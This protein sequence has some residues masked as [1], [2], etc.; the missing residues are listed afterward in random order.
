DWQ[1]T[2]VALVVCPLLAAAIR[3]VARHITQV[4]TDAR[5]KES[6]LYS[7][8]QRAM[9]SIKVIQAFTSEEEEHR[10]FID[11][12]RA[13]LNA[14]LNLYTVQTAYSMAVNVIGALGTA[15]VIWFGA[16]HVMAGTLTIGDLLVFTTYLASLYAPINTISNTYG[17]IQGA[18][19]GIKRVFEI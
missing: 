4:A 6:D 2:L 18:K 10:S 15:A 16:M 11:V 19:V 7:V 17:L 3:Q 12:S 9:S 13:S 14:N 1:L 5:E 8:A